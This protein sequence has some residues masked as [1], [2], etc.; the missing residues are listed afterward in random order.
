M[1]FQLNTLKKN[2]DF[3]FETFIGELG[4]SKAFLM[5]EKTGKPIKEWAD[6]SA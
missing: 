2:V 3:K 4:G 1:T 6:P 5:D